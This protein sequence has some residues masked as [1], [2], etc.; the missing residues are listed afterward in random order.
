MLRTDARSSRPTGA[1]RLALIGGAGLS[2]AIGLVAIAVG[3]LLL[4]AVKPIRR[5]MAGVH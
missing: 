5:L 4:L 1:I 2:V 3:V